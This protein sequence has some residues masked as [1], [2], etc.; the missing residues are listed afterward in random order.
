MSS[1]KPAA[2]FWQVAMLVA[3]A[4]A[5]NFPGV[6]EM[7]VFDEVAFSVPEYFPGGH[8]VHDVEPSMST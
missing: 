3:A 4:L 5:E 7:H 1:K 8:A 2:Q 6:Q